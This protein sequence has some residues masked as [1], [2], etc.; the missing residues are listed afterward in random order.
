MRAEFKNDD[1]LMN[2]FI[3]MNLLTPEEGLHFGSMGKKIREGL[4]S[5]SLCEIDSLI[6]RCDKKCVES[7]AI[8][9]NQ[10]FCELRGSMAGL[11]DTF[12]RDNPNEYI[13]AMRIMVFFYEFLVV[14]G[15]PLLMYSDS[16]SGIGCVQPLA[17]FGTFFT[18]LSLQMPFILFVRLDNPFDAQDDIK[19]ENLVASTELALFQSMRCQ[20]SSGSFLVP[21][22]E[23]RLARIRPPLIY[24]V[25]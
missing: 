16:T 5:V 19:A 6:A 24:Q 12:V 17:F 3:T 21:Q 7:K 25:G 15:Y 4:C 22:M 11:H 23:D 10:K 8:I 9:I 2:Q 18:L 13:L 20:F 1:E 14:T